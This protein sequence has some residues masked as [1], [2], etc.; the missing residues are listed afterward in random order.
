MLLESAASGRPIITTNR[1]GCREVVDD[2][3]NGYVVEEKSSQDLIDKIEMFLAK[4]VEERKAMGLAGRAKVEKEFDRRIV[5][6][7]Y[8]EEV[9]LEE[10]S[11]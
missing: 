3:I 1:G 7:K 5:V 6:R 2:G 9:E 4:S 8:L 10:N 11:K